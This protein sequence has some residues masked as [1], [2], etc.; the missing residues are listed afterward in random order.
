MV[1]DLHQLAGESALGKLTVSLHEQHDVIVGYLLA[2][3]ILN[4]L[5]AH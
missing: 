3:P 4:L 5:L 1:K 2:N